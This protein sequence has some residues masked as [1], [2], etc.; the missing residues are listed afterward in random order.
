MSLSLTSP[1]FGDEGWIPRQFTC[2]GLDHQPPLSWAGAPAGT[3][4]FALIAHDPDAPRGDF[5]HWV[6]F[7]I[8]TSVNEITES[9]MPTTTGVPGVNDF[10]REGWGGPCPPSGHGPHHYVF[11]LYA[12]DIESTGLNRGASR[13]EVEGAIQ[14]HILDQTRLTGLFERA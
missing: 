13:A 2:D 6:V 12:L 7:N 10:G 1:A 14:G 5:T 8:P 9:A 4:A 11:E 3:R